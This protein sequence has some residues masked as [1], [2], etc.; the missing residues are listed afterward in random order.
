MTLSIS[1][2]LSPPTPLSF[3]NK[4]LSLK[5][6]SPLSF[7]SFTKELR[8]KA[9]PGRRLSSITAK[10][11]GGNDTADAPD[12]IISAV[13]Y[14]YPFFDG[15]QYG[16]YVITQFSPIQTLIQ[17]LVPAIRVFKSFPFNGF[18]V[19]LTLY[20]VVVRNRNFS[21]YVRFNTMQAIVL[22]VL[23]IF[24]DLLKR[25][26]NPRGRL[27]LDLVM[28]LDSTVF[29]FLLISL[30]YGSSTCLLGQVPRLP[31]VAEAAERQVP[32]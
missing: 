1:N 2:L 15:I 16:K 8:N 18:L 3:S 22:D 5:Q 13:C 27:G 23:L 20:F 4:R 24:P 32:F 11:N 28:S 21:R 25:T 9:K 10:N 31:I 30:I 6:S 29:L 19:F 12:R 17:P 7:T 26:F 14:F